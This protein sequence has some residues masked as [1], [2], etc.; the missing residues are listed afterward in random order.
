MREVWGKAYWCSHGLYSSPKLCSSD[1]T[2][3]GQT[4]KRGQES[5]K[6]QGAW[7]THG[8]SKGPPGIPSDIGNM[9]GYMQGGQSH[10]SPEIVDP[11]TKHPAAFSSLTCPFMQLIY[12]GRKQFIVSYSVYLVRSCRVA[13]RQGQMKIRNTILSVFMMMILLFSHYL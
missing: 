12:Y 10:Q 7:D 2:K 13:Q 8:G 9:K 11:Q 6:G 1:T 3:E 4:G 5:W